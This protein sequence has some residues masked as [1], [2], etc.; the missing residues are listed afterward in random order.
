M[1]KNCLLII[2]CILA[3][4]FF[5]CATDENTVDNTSANVVEP[6]TKE[7]ITNEDVLV[8][9]VEEQAINE[10]EDTLD[11]ASASLIQF[12]LVRPTSSQ[13]AA[14]AYN[15]G[16]SYLHDSDYENAEKQFLYALDIDPEFVDAMD[17]LGVVYR[18]QGRYEDAE[19]IYLKSISMNENNEVPYTNLALVYQD[20]KRYQ[21]A[22][23]IYLD[24][25][26]K[27]P[28]STEGNYGLGTFLI[29]IGQYEYALYYLKQACSLYLE[30]DSPYIIDGIKALGLCY[31][32]MN[33]FENAKIWMNFILDYDPNDGFAL[34]L[35]SAMN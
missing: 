7:P 1:R 8:A 33:D 15:A 19:E 32:Y 3:C 30:Q 2:L 34:N 25:L 22:L 18:R 24:L 4:V 35:I 14:D 17:N 12:G 6:A 31:Y 23:D 13:T 16:L 26:E 27:M 9:D 21:D 5:G 28:D 29:T 11:P 20:M 10:P